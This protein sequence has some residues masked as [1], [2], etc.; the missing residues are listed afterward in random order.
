MS[1]ASHLAWS[2]FALTEGPSWWRVHRS[3]KVDSSKKD[4]GR[5]VGHGDWSL[6]SPF[7]LS[8]ILPVGGSLFVSSTF[9]TRTF[10]CK[11]THANITM[12]TGQ[13]SQ[14]QSAVPLTK[15]PSDCSF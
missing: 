13:G 15:A 14:F 11:I 2:I 6:P 1:L 3:A 12:V 10:F 8:Q 7:N 5:L 4:S 9:L